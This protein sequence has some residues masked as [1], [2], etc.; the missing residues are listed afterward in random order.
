[1]TGLKQH[2]VSWK[3]LLQP[4]LLASLEM[5][6]CSAAIWLGLLPRLYLHRP[7]E[8]GP[9]STEVDGETAQSM[10][11]AGTNSHQ[12]AIQNSSQEKS[13]TQGR[14]KSHPWEKSSQLPFSSDS[15][16]R[17]T[18]FISIAASFESQ[19]LYV[20]PDHWA[21]L[22]LRWGEYLRQLNFFG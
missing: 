22:W 12:M 19:M 7:V 1:M 4:V 10:Y 14:C 2:L 20:R 5:Q 9:L 11:V 13:V 15:S 21:P 6:W 3:L 16:S 18:V 8:P 17:R